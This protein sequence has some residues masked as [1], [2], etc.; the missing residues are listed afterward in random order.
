MMSAETDRLSNGPEMRAVAAWEVVS[1]ISSALIASWAVQA[2]A[3]G[4][5]FVLSI[6]IASAFA[7][8]IF[9]HRARGES[10]RDLGFRLDTFPR[11]VLLLVPV[12][13]VAS[14]ALIIIGWL[15][16]GLRVR[17]LAG[18]GIILTPLWGFTWGLLQ[19]YVLQ[20]FIN[21]RVQLFL[22]RGVRSVL[23]VACIFALLHLPNPV[24]TLATLAGGVL[25]AA[26]YQRA[27]SL[28]A[29]A[30]SHSVMTWVLI[31]TLPA[32]ALKGLRIGYKFFG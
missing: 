25:W 12:M 18:K 10:A 11:A 32:S 4:N 1:I 20:G 24:L 30:L 9:S 17:L 29:L 2:L 27:P 28:Y 19:Q 6:P 23:V 8:M 16:G 22:G 26:V 14:I 31:S 3:E 5:R 7:L 15:S 13:I 21:R